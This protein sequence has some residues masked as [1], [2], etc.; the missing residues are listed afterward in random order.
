MYLQ[1]KLI[2][3]KIHVLLNTL[4]FLRIIVLDNGCVMEF[5]TPEHLLTDHNSIFYELAKTAGVVK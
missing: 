2:I 1:S 3:V 5:D 4:Y